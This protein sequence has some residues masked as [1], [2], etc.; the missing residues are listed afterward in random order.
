MDIASLIYDV[1]K[2]LYAYY[3]KAKGR[4]VDLKDIRAQ[5]LWMSEKSVLIQEVLQ[6]NGTKAEDKSNIEQNLRKCNDAVAELQNATAKLKTVGQNR[7]KTFAKMKSR[8]EALGLKTAWPLKK[9]TIAALA[10]YARTCHSALDSS[11]SLLHLNISVSQIEKMQDLDRA[12]MGG[13]TSMDAALQDMRTVFQRHLAE[14]S[15]RLAEQSEQ[16]AEQTELLTRERDEEQAQ[17]IVKS[18]K[19]DGMNNRV[20]QIT[21]AK[22]ETYAWLFTPEAKGIA[23]AQQLVQFLNTGCGLFWIYGDPASG[24]STL[25]KYLRSPQ[26]EHTPLWRWEGD[27]EVTIACHFCWIA[28]SPIQKTQLALL[29][30]LLHRILQNELDLVPEVCQSVWNAGAGN[31]HWSVYQLQDYLRTAVVASRKRLCFFIDGLDELL[32]ESDH[33]EVVEYLKQLANGNHVKIII[34][35][36]PWSVFR[37]HSNASHTLHMKSINE[38]AIVGHLQ[39]TLG[40]LP[41]MSGVSWRCQHGKSECEHSNALF[42]EADAHGDAHRFIYDLVSRSSGNFLWLSLVTN[43]MLRLSKMGVGM[44]GI[45]KH[46]DALPDD[47]D[48][49]FRKMI[50]ERGDKQASR[51]TATAL[52]I[53]LLPHA[54]R[55]WISFWLLIN[56]TNG[57]VPSLEVPGFAL[58]APYQ[59]WDHESVK[60]MMQQTEVFLDECC[61][62]ILDTSSLQDM[63][64]AA[65]NRPSNSVQAHTGISF[66]HRTIHDFLRTQGMQRLLDKHKPQ[67]FHSENLELEVVLAGAKV[68]LERSSTTLTQA[69][70]RTKCSESTREPMSTLSRILIDDVCAKLL[71]ELGERSQERTST[72]S[73]LVEEMEEVTMHYLFK[74][75]QSLWDPTLEQTGQVNINNHDLTTISTLCV[76]YA[77]CGCY[78]LID[79]IVERSPEYVLFDFGS[80]FRRA[81]VPFE[82]DAKV[83]PP[84][85]LPP[86]ILSSFNTKL[87]RKLL[88]AGADPNRKI[89]I[90]HMGGGKWS[91]VWCDFLARLSGYTPTLITAIGVM[92]ALV[93]SLE[94]DGKVPQRMHPTK[95]FSSPDIQMAIKLFLE[96]GAELEIS[97]PNTPASSSEFDGKV[98]ERSDGRIDPLA[99]LR[100][101]LPTDADSEW[102]A[103]LD[104]Y[105]QPKKREELR[106][107]R[108]KIMDG[109]E[110][111]WKDKNK[112]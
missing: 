42:P 59:V 106:K 75:G 40:S 60:S 63:R 53:A 16:I 94:R 96:F 50:F 7:R 88:A 107:A 45:R 29:R 91:T 78:R 80:L 19:F 20:Q 85:E 71:H 43:T 18:L 41:D 77:S 25:M 36:R 5:L 4:D 61:R 34:S 30:T 104:S 55:S 37:G 39:K 54:G 67:S 105:L 6:R 26:R 15:M 87:L 2:D 31:G 83:F 81:L 97:R 3:Q 109:L 28:G 17:K 72:I 22:D 13:E 98:E 58:V 108:Q 90:D 44:V 86:T 68:R 74:L 49:Y 93:P 79:A 23:E 10:G 101:Y 92:S 73:Q 47:L 82:R 57:K 56:S 89:A 110:E 70:D 62:D 69:Q 1:S 100:R 52:S 32:P 33:G 103:L 27:E 111:R 66:T 11:V 48:T 65:N 38:K 12:I 8:L 24:K 46:I 64:R 112:G 14:I 21:D 102:P 51:V 9:E 84:T 76:S 95:T 99:T 35:S